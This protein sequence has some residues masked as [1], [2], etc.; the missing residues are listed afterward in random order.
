MGKHSQDYLALK[1]T[2]AKHNTLTERLESIESMLEKLQKET[3]TLKEQLRV[4]CYQ[5]DQITATLHKEVVAK[6]ELV[7]ELR[8]AY[9]DLKKLSPK[10]LG[11]SRS[12]S[13]SRLPAGN[14][15]SGLASGGALPGRPLRGF[16]ARDPTLT[17]GSTVMSEATT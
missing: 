1:E 3:S 8:E 2:S 12:S 6:E 4:S 9:D 13:A 15:S 16:V 17:V 10:S 5:T 11:G 7:D 14:M